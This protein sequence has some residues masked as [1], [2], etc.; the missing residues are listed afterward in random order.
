MRAMHILVGGAAAFFTLIAVGRALGGSIG[1]AVVFLALV[2]A[3][4]TV[5]VAAALGLG[6][7]QE[8][9]ATIGPRAAE[10]CT[11]CH[12][13]MTTIGDYRVCASCDQIVVGR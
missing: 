3:V 8:W 9:R 6:S 5:G 1:A 2:V 4:L 10:M 11:S 13:P 7:W 12:R